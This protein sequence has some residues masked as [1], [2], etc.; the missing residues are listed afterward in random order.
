MRLFLLPFYLLIFTSSHSQIKFAD[1]VSYSKNVALEYDSLS[2]FLGFRYEQYQGQTLTIL[3][4]FGKFKK[5]RY[6]GFVKN[7]NRSIYQKSNIYS[8]SKK[9]KSIVD[10]TPYND[11]ID[12]NFTV[13]NTL[14]TKEGLFLHLCDSENSESIY[15]SYDPSYE[16]K[17]PF[18][19]VGYFQ[20]MENDLLGRKYYARVNKINHFARYNQNT[21]DVYGNEFKAEIGSEW[22][23]TEVQAIE[24]VLSSKIQLKL[25]GMERD[26]FIIKDLMKEYDIVEK[27]RYDVVK[28]SYS[29]DIF[30]KVLKHHYDLGWDAYL[31]RLSLGRPKDIN[32]TT[33]GSSHTEQWVYE[34]RYLYFTDGKLTSI[35]N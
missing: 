16:N 7:P 35:Q 5:E 14:K 20:K 17:F 12:R 21:T 8:P 22:E 26:I 9:V 15:F 19:V 24:S 6:E 13:K 34:G 18:I 27:E 10:G 28:S 3:P 4:S 30:I 25:T 33:T 32:R 11:L 1:N 23:V 29:E 2:N 31:V